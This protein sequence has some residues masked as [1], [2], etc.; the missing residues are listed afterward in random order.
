MLFKIKKSFSSVQNNK[1]ILIVYFNFVVFFSAKIGLEIYYI[2]QYWLTLF[3]NDFIDK[4]F[5]TFVGC[6]VKNLDWNSH[7]HFYAIASFF[8]GG[9]MTYS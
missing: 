3:Q 1:A 2:L 4:H 6:V 9:T 5:N 7:G 8:W